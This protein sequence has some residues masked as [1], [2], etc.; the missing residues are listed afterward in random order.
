MLLRMYLRF[1]ERRGWKARADRPAG[2]RGGGDQERDAPR[3][4]ATTPTGT[5]RARWACTASCGSRPS[6]RRSAATPRSPRCTSPRR[7]TRTSRS[8]SPTRTSAST[9]TARAA[10]A[11]STSTSPTRRCGSR[12]CRPGIV[13]TCQNERSQGRNRE[14]AMQVLRA[15]LYQKALDERRAEEE[16]R[17]GEKKSIEWGSQIRSYVLHP[18]RMVKDHRTGFETGDTDRVLDGG[19]TPFVE[20]Y[21]QVRRG[22]QPRPCLLLTPGGPKAPAPHPG[23]PRSARPGG[24][25]PRRARAGRGAAARGGARAA[26]RPRGR[27]LGPAD[28]ADRERRAAPRPD[29]LSGRRRG[30]G[31]RDA[32]RAPR[33]ARPRRRSASRRETC[34]TWA[35]CRRSR[36]SP[37]TTSSPTSAAIPHPYPFRLQESEIAEL[38]EVPLSAASRPRGARDAALPGPRGA[39]ALLPLRRAGDLGR[40]GED[41]E[42]AARRATLTGPVSATARRLSVERGRCRRR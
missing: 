7:S 38:I 12:T 32:L 13:V 28:A 29:R 34:D 19:L 36:P 4:R 25:R 27:S 31:R 9:P 40:D 35:R 18:Y 30:G 24:P 42:G 21:L 17:A 33:F 23:W 37:T 26:L 6:T 20:A 11:A 3:R 10:P 15:R 16:K 22:R 1:A 5:S 14:M 39:G 8:R 2:R 41:A